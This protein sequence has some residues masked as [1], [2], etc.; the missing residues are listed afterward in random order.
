M[1]Q[2]NRFYRLTIGDYKK[3]EGIQIDGLQIRFDVQK[4]ADNKRNGNSASIEVY[5]LSATS[6]QK[7]Q[8]EYLVCTLE[9][10]YESPKNLIQLVNGNVVETRTVKNGVDTVTQIILGEGYSDLNF[11][12]ISTALPPG[13]T[14]EDV[15][16]ACLAGMPGVS[17]GAIKGTN[18]NAPLP[19]GYTMTGTPK[20]SLNDFCEAFRYEWRISNNK[21]EVS[22][23][24]GLVNTNK[25]VAPVIGIESGLIDI[26]FYTSGES[27]KLKKDSTRRQ[28]LQFKALLN[29]E[30]TPGQLIRVESSK[31]S[32][33]YRV[34]SARYTG[35]FRG[36]D[37][38][39]DCFCGIV[40]EDD[41]T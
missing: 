29:A 18:L 31:I 27:S 21:L 14:R 33:W 4:S 11:N 34:K 35:D 23:E 37:W 36:N 16:N 5:N 32:G 2:R 1:Y 9:V 6:L 40:L 12:K 7:L 15:V 22:D 26:P 13:K 41:L 24:N 28:G 25:D 3:G 10:G 8:S 30:V 20:D 38:F 39:M 19:F 17:R